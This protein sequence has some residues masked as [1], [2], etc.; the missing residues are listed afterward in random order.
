MEIERN[1]LIML[2]YG[3]YMHKFPSSSG[4]DLMIYLDNHFIANNNPILTD[5][6][7]NLVHDVFNEVWLSLQIQGVNRQTLRM[8]VNKK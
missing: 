8:A 1:Y 5:E 7:K 3:F 4:K 6:E 2:L